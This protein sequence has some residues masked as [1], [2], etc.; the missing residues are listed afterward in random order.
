MGWQQAQEELTRSVTEAGRSEMSDYLSYLSDEE[1]L[2]APAVA[3]QMLS[4][5]TRG[6]EDKWSGRGNDAARAYH[7]GELAAVRRWMDN[8]YDGLQAVKGSLA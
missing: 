5:L 6:A 3:V 8:N 2:S 7:D 4:Q 1:G